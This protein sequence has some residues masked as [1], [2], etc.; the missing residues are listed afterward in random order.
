MIGELAQQRDIRTLEHCTG[1][2]ELHAPASRQSGNGSIAVVVAATDG[3]HSF[4]D[5]V[6]GSA[7]I[8]I[9]LVE[10]NVVKTAQIAHLALNVCFNKHSTDLVAGGEALNLAVGNGAKKSGL[11]TVVATEETIA[12]TTN[13]LELC[14]V[15]QNLGTIGKSK[16]G[17]AKD[18]SIALSFSLRRC[19][20]R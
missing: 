10:E 8:L 19:Q 4:A 15:K 18:F 2:S 14:F 3:L 11:A 20:R 6:F 5:L 12:H 7:A 9:S 13:D 16:L 17:V 1:K